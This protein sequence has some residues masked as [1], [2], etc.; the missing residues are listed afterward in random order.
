MANLAKLAIKLVADMDKAQKDFTSMSTTIA[1]IEKSAKTATPS[2]K[3]LTDA[4]KGYGIMQEAV[5][6]AQEAYDNS[7]VESLLETKQ[8]VTQT[9][10][11]YGEL[12]TAVQTLGDGV[13]DDIL[14]MTPTI[15]NVQRAQKEVEKLKALQQELAVGDRWMLDESIK[16]AQESM[17]KLGN[18]TMQTKIEANMLKSTLMGI[19][20]LPFM[21]ISIVLADIIKGMKDFGS[22]FNEKFGGMPAKIIQ[23]TAAIAATVIVIGLANVKMTALGVSTSYLMGLWKSSLIYQGL[24]GFISLLGVAYAKTMALL[25]AQYALNAAWGI[26]LAATGIGLIVAAVAAIGYGVYKLCTGFGKTSDAIKDCEDRT[27]AWRDRMREIY[28]ATDEIINKQKQY[29]DAQ[30][31]SLEKYK[32]GLKNIENALNLKDVLK[33]RR[34][35]IAD[36]MTRVTNQWHAAI[37]SKKR[38]QGLIDGL[39]T[40]KDQLQKDWKDVNDRLREANKFQKMHADAAKEAERLEYLKRQYGNLMDKTITAQ[41]SYTKTIKDLD[42]DLKRKVDGNAVIKET[43]ADLIRLNAANQFRKA[44]GIVE[45]PMEKLAAYTESL[46]AALA[47]RV[48]DEMEHAALLKDAELKWCETTIASAKEQ[49]RLAKEAEKLADEHRRMVDKFRGMSKT[50]VEAFKELSV[51]LESVRSA[52]SPA[53]FA[54]AKDK[55]L[56]DLAGGLGIAQYLSDQKSAADRLTETYRK[57]DIYACEAGLSQQELT[58]AQ[59]RAKE[60]LEKQSEYYSLYQK[61]QDAMLTTQQRLKRELDRI[62]DEA[63]QWGWDDATVKMMNQIKTD[64]IIGNANKPLL[65]ENKKH[66]GLLG[67]INSTLA[68]NEKNAAIEYGTV[69]YYEA[70][71][72]G[73]KPLVEEGKKQTKAMN[74]VANAITRVERNTRQNNNQRVVIFS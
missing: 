32:T 73:N 58:A 53:E 4:V 35:E 27:A 16:K 41:D 29:I 22:Q 31:T 43:E 28:N 47:N 63:K 44:L 49:E 26:F 13:S 33:Q 37:N 36:E 70:Q 61:A 15:S 51:D 2:M 59:N 14:N 54:T 46:N 30:M 42:A 39:K 19:N 72:K 24:A 25:A 21:V 40:L 57:L 38:D 52:L 55:L 9:T 23:V 56:A 18:D 34:E 6:K 17:A 10:N 68:A 20:A 64:E 5:K 69:A 67:D 60:A 62:A 45:S 7:P 66:T 12:K 3:N 50:P 65:D 74:I 71:M 1:S 11:A 48:I 8:L